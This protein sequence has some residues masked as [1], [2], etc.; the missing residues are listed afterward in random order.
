MKTMRK[1][2]GLTTLIATLLVAG[3]A[4]AAVMA[5]I[6]KA[7]TGQ[8]LKGSV[9]WQAT[10]RQYVIQPEGSPVQYKLSPSDVAHIQVERPP[11]LDSAIKQVRSGNYARALPVLETIMKEYT[12]LEHD[13]TA[14]QYLAHSYLKTK[15]PRKAVAMCD[16]VMSSNPKAA[17]D[18]QFAGIYWQA[19]LETDQYIKLNK[20]LGIAIE[21]GSRQLAAVAQIKRGDIAKQKGDLDNAL[22]DGYLR[23][24]VFFQGIKSVQPEALFKAA[25]CFEEKG[26][27]SYAE[28]MRKELLSSYPQS[29]QARQLRGGA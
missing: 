17:Q 27:H 15:E 26:Q 18:E 10:T 25:Q 2:T 4:N 20:A 3:M 12:M 11:Q 23:T 9:K 24:V 1:I 7:G 19:L 6:T 5:I 28:K 16:K 29:E 8:E 14:A 21:G 22:I 13:V